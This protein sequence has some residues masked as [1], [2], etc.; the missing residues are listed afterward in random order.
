MIVAKEWRKEQSHVRQHER[1]DGDSSQRCDGTTT[2]VGLAREIG[3]GRMSV[4]QPVARLLGTARKRDGMVVRTVGG[5]PV[6]IGGDTRALGF[7]RATRVVRTTGA[8]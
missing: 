4:E 2:G 1:S 5:L 7:S 6:A 8:A 3:R